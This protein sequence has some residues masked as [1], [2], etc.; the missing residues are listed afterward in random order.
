MPSAKCARKKRAKWRWRSARKARPS[1]PPSNGSATNP[2]TMSA[3]GHADRLEHRR[4]AGE[5]GRLEALEQ[6]V[7]RRGLCGPR[8]A[9]RDRQTSAHRPRATRPRPRGGSV[10]AP[11]RLASR[12]PSAPS[13]SGTWA[14]VGSGRPSSARDEQSGAGSSRSGRRRARP[15]R[16]PGRRRR[17]RRRGCRRTRRRCGARRGRRRRLIRAEQPIDERDALAAARRRSDGGR[18]A[19]ARAP[20]A[21]RPTARGRCPGRRPPAACRGAPTPPRGSRRGCRSTGTRGP[22]RPAARSPTRLELGAFG[23]ADRPPS[24][25]SPSA[26]R[27]ASCVARR[28]GRT[29]SAVEVLDP[30]RGSG[31]LRRARTARP[32]ARC[33]G[34]RRAASPVGVGAKRPSGTTL[35]LEGQPVRDVGESRRVAIAPRSREARCPRPHDP[36][37]RVVEADPGLGGAVVVGSALVD[38]VGAVGEHAEAV[39]EADRDPQLAPSDVVELDGLPLAEGRRAAPQVDDDVPGRGRGRSDPACPAPGGLEVDPAQAPGAS[40][41]GC[42]ARSRSGSPAGPRRRAVGLDE[43]PALVAMHASVDSGQAVQAG[44]EAFIEAGHST[45]E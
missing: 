14:Y 36:D 15:R 43:Q 8:E 7:Q 34:C 21:R 23:L 17:P 4:L 33:A 19:R 20:P 28:P 30:H 2:S 1:E 11:W 40:A 6:L 37:V 38:E 18:L 26:S 16:R 3:A 31:A 45:R 41:S 32:A 42:P 13:T 12:A 35:T 44:F 22:V 5:R 39:A 29:R 25:S 10:T 27:S 9:D 24:H